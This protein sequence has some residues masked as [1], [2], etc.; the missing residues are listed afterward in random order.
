MVNG[1]IITEKEVSKVYA[2]GGK[3]VYLNGV[4]GY[5]K[6]GFKA[7]FGVIEVTGTGVKYFTQSDEE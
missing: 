7:I 3:I 2:T 4:N 1:E 6:Y 5:Y